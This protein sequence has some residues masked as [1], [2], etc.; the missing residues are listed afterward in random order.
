MTT[1]MIL[2]IVMVMM[3][4]MML[5]E[6]R[7]GRG[8]ISAMMRKAMRTPICVNHA[9]IRPPVPGPL[10]IGPCGESCSLREVPL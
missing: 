4:R 2:V 1:M 9:A 7:G 10:L 8:E 3:F 5:D 6:G